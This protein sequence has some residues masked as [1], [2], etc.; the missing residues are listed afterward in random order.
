MT[1][2]LH[3]TMDVVIGAALFVC[4]VIIFEKVMRWVKSK[5]GRKHG[6]PD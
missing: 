6:L 3:E 4:L 5:M 1:P 2:E